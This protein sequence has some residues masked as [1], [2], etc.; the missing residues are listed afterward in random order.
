LGQQIKVRFQLKSDGGTT[1]DGYYFDDFKVFYSVPSN[2][3]PTASFTAP[4]SI[5][6]SSTISFTDFSTNSPSTWFWD[7]GDGTSSTEQNPTHTYATTGSYTVSLTVSNNVGTNTTTQNIVVNSN[8]LVTLASSDSDNVV[9][10]NE[11]LVQLIPTPSNATLTGTGVAN[12][13]FDPAVAGIGINT[14][15][16]NFTDVNGCQGSAQIT[17]I[18]EQCASLEKQLNAFI[19]VFPNPNGGAFKLNGFDENSFFQIMDFNGK[20]LHVGTVSNNIEIAI[21]DISSGFYYLSGI[22]KGQ[23]V[24]L[25]IAVLK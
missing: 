17:I 2:N 13:N 19:Q 23:L 16:A 22:S 3:P 8:P 7:F 9:C 14:I 15:S 21:P 20:V 4:N 10:N 11:G 18:V 5:C 1:A 12:S 25:K 24:S 6:E